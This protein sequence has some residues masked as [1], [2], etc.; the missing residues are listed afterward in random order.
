[1][2]KEFTHQFITFCDKKIIKMGQK[3]CGPETEVRTKL[4]VVGD[5]G[6][7]K[8]TM[9]KRYINGTYTDVSL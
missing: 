5:C 8:T 9:I 7:G 3:D 1:V 6:C 4:V 2:K